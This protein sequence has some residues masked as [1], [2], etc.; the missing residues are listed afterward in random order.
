MIGES[1]RRMEEED[2]PQLRGKFRCGLMTQNQRINPRLTTK[3]LIIF[4]ST[5]ITGARSQVRRKAGDAHGLT[6]DIEKIT[7]RTIT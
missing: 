7:R 5:F 2:E 4:N 1:G 3:G 6:K